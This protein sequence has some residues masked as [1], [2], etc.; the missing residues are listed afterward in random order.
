MTSIVPKLFEEKLWFEFY[1]KYGFLKENIKSVERKGYSIT[2]KNGK[3]EK[4]GK[5][6]GD[7]KSYL[8]LRKAYKITDDITYDQIIEW[9]VLFSKHLI[10]LY[11]NK[12]LKKYIDS[13][14][15]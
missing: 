13:K 5:F 2:L 15:F 7:G 12:K 1:K 6:G 8:A 9:V 4:F 14:Y 10:K 3:V 11:K